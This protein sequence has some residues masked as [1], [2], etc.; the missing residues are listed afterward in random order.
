MAKAE[1]KPAP[2]PVPLTVA[3]LSAVDLLA[4]GKNDTETAE[5]LKVHR[6]TVT[7]WR[8]YSP[9]FKAALAERRKAI[10]GTAADK[11]RVLVPKALDTLAAELE[12]G[13]DKA[14]VALAIIKLAGGTIAVVPNDP[15]DPEDYVREAVKAERKARSRERD[16]ELDDIIAGTFGGETPLETV[17]KRLAALA[18]GDSHCPTSGHDEQ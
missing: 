11:L 8:C 15:T 17:R 13:V 5:A 4:G 6:V 7:R 1:P 18:A 2:K 3:Q 9:E 12:H 16:G 10:W 14:Q